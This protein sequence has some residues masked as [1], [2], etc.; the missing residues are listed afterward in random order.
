MQRPGQHGVGWRVLH[1]L[2]GVHHDDARASLGHHTKIVG[3]QQQRGTGAIGQ[4]QQQVD[5]LRLHG[6]IQRGGW[7][8]GDQQHRIADQ[9]HG[10]HRALTHPTRELVRVGVTAALRQRDADSLQH[11]DGAIPRC[12]AP[13][14]QMTACGFGDLLSDGKNRIER[15]HGFLEDHADPPSAHFA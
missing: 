6:D 12:L 1:H 9:R 4:I 15:A 14:A 7:L 3:D 2:P 8:I 5:D 11:G 13:K 10:D